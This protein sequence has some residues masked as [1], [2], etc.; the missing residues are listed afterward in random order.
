MAQQ[1]R[2]STRQQTPEPIYG[3]TEVWVPAA[4]ARNH[5]RRWPSKLPLLLASFVLLLSMAILF[6]MI[7]LTL[8]FYASD[9]ILP[10]VEVMGVPVG[11][12]TRTEAAQLLA[13]QVPQQEVL[14]MH[15][16]GAWPVP[17]SELGLTLDTEATLNRAYEYGRTL[18]SLQRMLQRGPEVV[19]AW[20]LNVDQATAVLERLGPAVTVPPVDA[21]VQITDGEVLE[22]PAQTGLGL[23]IEMTLSGLLQ[24]P[25]QVIEDGRLPLAT[26][27]IN[28]QFMD[29]SELASEARRLLSKQVTLRAFDPIR[30]EYGEWVVKPSTWQSWLSL[31]V[32]PQDA[33]PFTWVVDEAAAQKAMTNQWP[34]LGE[35]RYLDA[36]AVVP[37]LI[38]V[39]TSGR[40]GADARVYHQPQQH[41]VRP[42]E[43]FASIGYYYGIPYPWI[44]QANPN[45]DA[46]SVGDTVTIPSPDDMLPLP[47]VENKR[48]VV[49]ISEQRAWAYEDGEL[50][51]EWPISTGIN[52]SPTSPGIFQIQSHEQEA[53]A[54]NWDLYMPSFMGVYRPVPGLDFM[55]GFHGFPTRDGATLLWTSDLGTPVTYG[56]ILLSS[57][58]AATLFNWAE[59]GVVVEVQR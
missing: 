37:Q 13:E 33:D 17:V 41:T 53:Y 14:L 45:L 40:T 5:Q 6:G 49:S 21:R 56:C 38:E 31:V 18:P 42:G 15:S 39:V 25:T 36:G 52:T 11:A 35:G 44:Q 4:H 43:S 29:V 32:S 27:V 7:A 9:M 48:I 30:N 20:S 50:L 54:A 8:V 58:N 47:V 57:E 59:E 22:I 26:R 23:D 46:L 19:P 24:D 10:G 16:A 2:R 1:L 51:W 3:P 28:P 12:R 55:N 34:W